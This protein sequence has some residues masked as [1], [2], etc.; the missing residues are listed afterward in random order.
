MTVKEKPAPWQP[1]PAKPK[2]ESGPIPETPR[3][4]PPRK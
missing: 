1:Q 2:K 4:I 3:R